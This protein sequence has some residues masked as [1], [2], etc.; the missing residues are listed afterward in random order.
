MW[1]R[2]GGTNIGMLDVQTEASADSTSPGP[3]TCWRPGSSRTCGTRATSASSSPTATRGHGAT[4]WRGPISSTTPASSGATRTSTPAAG[5]VLAQRARRATA[6]MGGASRWI[7]PTT[8]STP[9]ALPVLGK[10][11]TRRWAFCP[12]PASTTWVQRAGFLPRPHRWGIRRVFLG[13]GA[14]F[15]WQWDGRLESRSVSA[16][17]LGILS[18]TGEFL[19]PGYSSE[20]EFLRSRSRSATGST[21]G[22]VLPVRPGPP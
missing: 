19:M 21:S 12:G 11:S 3:R 18:D 6:P 2:L 5:C 8:S 16:T 1:G 10:G 22:R 14:E 13:G 17:P 15:Y 9:L 4:P 20:Y 7:I